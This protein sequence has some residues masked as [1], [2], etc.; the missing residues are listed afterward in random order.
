MAK[1]FKADDTKSWQ[2]R[3]AMELSNI[4]D[5]RLNW[6]NHLNQFDLMHRKQTC[7]SE[8]QKI[9]SKVYIQEKW[10]HISI[11]MYIHEW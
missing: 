8:T 11:K 4:A 3:G 6:F 9:H 10:V 7:L 1:I 2:A 5:G